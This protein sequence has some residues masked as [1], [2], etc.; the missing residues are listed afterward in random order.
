M[1][2]KPLHCLAWPREGAGEMGRDG[3]GGRAEIAKIIQNCSC[4]TGGGC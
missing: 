1:L 2:K 4:L 3:G